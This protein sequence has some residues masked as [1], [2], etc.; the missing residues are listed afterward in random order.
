[1]GN[2]KNLT[3]YAENRFCGIY[4]GTNVNLPQTELLVWHTCTHIILL[5]DSHYWVPMLIRCAAHPGM[6][7]HLSIVGRIIHFRWEILSCYIFT[8]IAVHM[9]GHV[10]VLLQ[11]S[12]GPFRHTLSNYDCNHCPG[13]GFSHTTVQE[14]DATAKITRA[15]SLVNLVQSD[16]QGNREE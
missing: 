3:K 4:C 9:T 15:F 2:L 8:R 14:F 5:I 6:L 7:P 16:K 13:Q 1:M 10:I 12:V 11:P